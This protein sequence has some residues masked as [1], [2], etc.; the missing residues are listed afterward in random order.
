MNRR[1]RF[2]I[3]RTQI[4]GVRGLC[5]EDI[6]GNYRNWLNDP[7]VCR[8][9]SHCVFPTSVKEL[10]TFVHSIEGDRS[11]IVW[12][13]DDLKSGTHIGNVALQ[14][15]NYIYRRAEFAILIGEKAFWGRG[16]AFEASSLLLKHGFEKLNLNRIYCG[17]AADNQ[18]MIK[19]A[20]KLKMVQEGLRR[21]DLFL[22]GR[23]VDTIEFGVLRDEFLGK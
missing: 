4:L 15:I 1:E 8:Y 13:I 9:N 17:T 10:E 11:R 2:Y 5:E 23:F 12:A 22:N 7:D 16:Y 19:L 20:K 6:P 3:Y 18:G 14:A 21:Q